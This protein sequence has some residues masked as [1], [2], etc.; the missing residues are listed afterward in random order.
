[1]DST[2]AIIFSAGKGLRLRP[3]TERTPK[4]LLEIIEGKALL[5]FTLESLLKIGIQDIFIN[6]SYAGD[7]FHNFKEEYKE[8]CNITL[9]EESEPLGQGGTILKNIFNLRK[10]NK[11]ICS[12]GDTY[13]QYDR[14]LFIDKHESLKSSLTILSDN[15]KNLPRE[16]LSSYSNHIKGC[17]LNNKPY[18]YKK[19]IFNINKRVN[20]LGEFIFNPNDIPLINF[21]EEFRGLFGTDD[22]IE[23]LQKNGKKTMIYNKKIDY[24]LS[25]NTLEEYENIKNFCNNSKQCLNILKNF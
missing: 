15:S 8:R 16:I 4:P 19:E 24:F 12:N 13:A 7:L 22:L 20:Y 25:M 3:L 18:Y 9:I 14:E 5:D 23:I 21:T 2:C 6:Y 10:Y 17:R 11:V 1:M